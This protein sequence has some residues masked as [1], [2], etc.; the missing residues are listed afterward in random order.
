MSRHNTV[1]KDNYTQAGRLTPDDMARERQK[2]ARPDAG[3][4]E[5]RVR[6]R[7]A[8]LPAGDRGEREST[9]RQTAREESE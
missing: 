1:N 2:Q 9:P 7:A 4:R 6:N 8:D 3:A 5:P